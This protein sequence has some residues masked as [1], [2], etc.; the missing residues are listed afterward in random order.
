MPNMNPNINIGIINHV[1]LTEENVSIFEDNCDPAYSQ[2][3]SELYLI[4]QNKLKY[5]FCDF[6][7]T[8][9]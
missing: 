6:V 9:Q 4:Y 1:T 7:I 8:K 2:T 3:F 5:L